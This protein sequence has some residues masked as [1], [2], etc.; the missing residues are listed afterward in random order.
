[1]GGQVKCV[2]KRRFFSEVVA[3][4]VADDINFECGYERVFVYKC[5]CCH[6]FHL[7][8]MNPKDKY[9]KSVD[10]RARN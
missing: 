10:D 6:N 2:A 8:R 7:T 3:Q 1:M 9:N 4:C 5:H